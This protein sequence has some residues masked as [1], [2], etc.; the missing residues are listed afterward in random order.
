MPSSRGSATPS[1]CG[2]GGGGGVSGQMADTHT[3]TRLLGVAQR[4]AKSGSGTSLASLRFARLRAVEMRR[5]RSCCLAVGRERRHRH[6][7]HRHL[8]AMELSCHSDVGMQLADR[9]IQVS[10]AHFGACKAA[11]PKG[12]AFCFLNY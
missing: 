5:R 11:A 9:H 4:W 2:T 1:D 8:A 7:R 6:L 10:I 12:P 3:S